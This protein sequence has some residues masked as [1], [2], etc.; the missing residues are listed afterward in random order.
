[1]KFKLPDWMISVLGYTL[2][3][4]FLLL[5]FVIPIAIL[6]AACKLIVWAIG[7]Y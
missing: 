6:A 4:L 2:G 3:G 7:G 5:T 1:M